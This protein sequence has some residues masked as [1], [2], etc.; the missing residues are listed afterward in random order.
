MIAVPYNNEKRASDEKRCILCDAC[1]CVCVT[2]HDIIS[3]LSP[4]ISPSFEKETLLF[5]LPF[6]FDIICRQSY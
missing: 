5:G 3:S 1:L 6:I 2:R 4:P